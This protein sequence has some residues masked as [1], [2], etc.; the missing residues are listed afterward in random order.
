MRL[1]TFNLLHGR[2]LADGVVD[3]DRLRAAVAAIDADVLGIQEVD[4]GQPRSHGLD[5]TAEV[6]AALGAVDHRFA[7]S[8]IGTP[9]H[10][11]RAATGEG[12]GA[13]EPAYGVGLA[14]RWPVRSWH[15]LRLAASRLRS[16]VLLPGRRSR[17]ILLDDEP[18]VVLAAVVET[19]AGPIT[20]AT[21]HLS[22]VPGWNARQ[23]RL[24][25]AGLSALPAP[26]L[27]LGDL[28]MPAWAV[29][30]VSPWRQLARLPT[31]PA[32]APRIQF[33]HALGDP[34]GGFPPVVGVE[35]PA[36]PLSDHRALVV[37][38]ASGESGP[39]WR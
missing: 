25:V 9:G 31:Y 19:P 20:V 15:V 5:L 27:L 10:R 6:A 24:A 22:F 35:A 13:G 11:W 18:R 3:A 16:P 36:L 14:S 7:P 2:S 8:L 12:N 23:L 26:R 1:A 34:D 28:N 30:L 37:T 29:A 39:R 33:D 32:H 17:V 38:L 21:T 4:R